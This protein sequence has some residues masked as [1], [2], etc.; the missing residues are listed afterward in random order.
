MPSRSY[1]A[2]DP[3][4][5]KPWRLGEGRQGVVLLHGF[6]STPPELRRLGEHLAASGYRCSAPLLAGHGTT[7]E[8]LGRTH[9][10]DW[11]A[12]ASTAIDELARDC[13]QVMVVGQSMGGTLALH[14]AATDTRI[15][16]VAALATPVWISGL[17]LRLL[18]YL[19][20]LVRWHHP[21]GDI[22][23]FDRSAVTELYSY[24]R[25]PTRAIHE[26]SRLMAQTRSELPTIRQPVLLVH[27][28]RDRTVDPRN[29]VDIA[30]ALVCSVDVRSEILERSG[31]AV[32]VDVDRHRVNALVSE[33]FDSHDDTRARHSLSA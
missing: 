23:L 12:S 15:R 18:P 26:L 33:W 10:Q 7:P 14:L 24:G 16:A 11:A 5:I 30:T 19:K 29:A 1:L 3:N 4:V 31:H 6:A 22:D 20:H 2:L 17:G 32:S 28:G 25:R 21:G 27:G 8:Q 13:D 9:W